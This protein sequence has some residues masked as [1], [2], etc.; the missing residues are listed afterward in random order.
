[1]R[2]DF[3]IFV[4]LCSSISAANTQYIKD[5]ENSI[6]E[7]IYSRKQITDTTQRNK[8]FFVEDMMLR[9][10]PTKSLF[11]GVKRLWHDSIS[12]IDY[13]AYESVLKAAI[14]KDANTAFFNT[15]GRTF[16]YTYKDM[17]KKEVTEC[18]YFDMTRWKYTEQ[19]NIPGWTITDSIKNCIGYDCV[20]ATAEF[21]GRKW[22]AWF[23]PEI[24][25]SDGPWKLCGLPGLILEAYDENHDYE[26][27][28]N[29]IYTTGIGAVGYMWYTPEE[30]YI[31][32]SRD[33]FFNKWLKAKRE[34]T[35]NKMKAAY[36]F[37]TLPSSKRIIKYDR[38]ETDYPHD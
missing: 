22:I 26:F 16:T 13:P 29:V 25:V 32:V 12:T 20:K 28:A 24:P 14:Q 33:Q 31:N 15:G 11:C 6:L 27:T 1:M 9:I 30:D 5:A 4:L 37:G 18:D 38:E 34:G 23:S 21:K 8:Q 17:A 2:T 10:G 7:I 36:G 35:A 19:L 3:Y